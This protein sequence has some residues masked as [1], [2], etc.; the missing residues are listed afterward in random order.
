MGI[1]KAIAATAYLDG[2]IEIYYL[3]S[4]MRLMM[5]KKYCYKV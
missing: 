1:M 2:L 5:F 4:R 3:R